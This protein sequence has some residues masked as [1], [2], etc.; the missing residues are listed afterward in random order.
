[1]A[2]GISFLRQA[3]PGQPKFTGEN[4]PDLGDKV[5][6]VTGAN[7]GVGKEI[8]QLVYSRNARVYL[9]ARSEKKTKKAIED[10]KAAI[11]NSSGELVFIQLDLADLPSIKTSADDFLRREQKLNV[12][13]NNAGLGFPEKGSTTNQG[14]E[15][16]LGVNCIGTFALTKYLTSTLVST[17]K[18]APPN[19]VRVVWASSSA[20]EAI[21][22]KNY[23]DNVADIAKKAPHEAYFLSKL[24]N[25]FHS[26]EF[27]ARHKADGV[28]SV[29]L[30][31]GNLDSD[32]WRTQGNIT[33]WVL[34]KTLLNPPVYGA[35][36]NIFAGFSPEVT[37]EKSGQFM[38]PWG[39]FWNI[40]H[41]MVNASKS[42]ALG[43]T[44]TAGDFWD[45]TES[46]IGSLSNTLLELVPFS[47][48]KSKRHTIFG[49]DIIIG[50]G[51]AGSTLATRISQGLPDYSILLI[52]AEPSAPDEPK[53]NIP[54]FRGSTIGDPLDCNRTTIPQASASNRILSVPMGKVLR[55]S[56][57]LNFMLWNRASVAEY[58]AWGSESFT[59]L[60]LTEA[61]FAV[62][63]T[64]GPI[65]TTLSRYV[66][67]NELFANSYLPQAG[68]NLEVLVNI[69]VARVN[70]KET[71][72]G[73]FTTTSI[74]FEDTT[75]IQARKE[76]IIS[77]GSLQSPG[78]LELSG[79]GQKEVLDVAGIEQLI[80]LPSVGENLQD[81]L[82]VQ[83]VC[84]LKEGHT[85]LDQ[86]IYNSTFAAEQLALRENQEC[87]IYDEA[88]NGISLL[89]Y[90]QA[91]G[92]DT[93]S[94]LLAL[95]EAEFGNSTNVIEQK[96]LDLLSDDS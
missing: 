17:A 40:S 16:Q 2:G 86:L 96:K 11:P 48:S 28:V 47:E 53:I 80:D 57:A 19:S 76:V 85:S 89:S 24:G 79:I 23:M 78:L 45:W 66:P 26:T 75:I 25:Y 94:A 20:A 44:G 95:A 38:A 36:T 9:M 22:P 33:S 39:R 31:P 6:V 55:G 51:T 84:Q 58:D 92:N 35:Y 69:R 32:F 12:L 37:L 52:E 27:A 63:R 72:D 50:G 64:Q 30:N 82:Q 21:T 4:I 10:I 34:R 91:F 61:G 14:Y 83:L 49:G 71:A 54:A 13:F 56:S 42:R 90:T 93:T 67:E 70:V 88:P 81:H 65:H 68:P 18:S 74:T 59:N 5:V 3:F 8:A 1:M 7:T 15:I 77:A 41:D 43:G 62:R 73:G 87:S 46:Q 60:N 29:S